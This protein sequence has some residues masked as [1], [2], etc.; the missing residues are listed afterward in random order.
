MVQRL[1]SSTIVAAFL[2]VTATSA[3]AA[4]AGTV[5]QETPDQWRASKLAGVAIYGPN[6]Q[7][8]G[9]ISD[10][11]MSKDGKAQ[12]VII[13]VGGFLGI[14]EKDVAVPYDQVKF[15]DQP[16]TPPANPVITNNMA[17]PA[18][19]NT[20]ASAPG[21]GASNAAG[22]G[23][24]PASPVGL[25][26]PADTLGTPSVPPMTGAMGTAQGTAG[27]MARSTAY[28]DHGMIDMT[29]DQLKAAPTFKFAS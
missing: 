19:N 11:I 22:G 20:M 10:V 16:M 6:N 1:I 9:K 4:D 28:P 23:I 7:S 24:A 27:G 14:G 21:T 3:F 13:G 26:T 25:G 18:A 8:V 12:Y 17:A 5:T 2:T 15:S 29:A